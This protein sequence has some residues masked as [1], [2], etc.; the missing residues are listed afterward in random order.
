MAIAIPI[1]LSL[2]YQ[3]SNVDYLSSNNNRL[4][5]WK[6]SIKMFIHNP[7]YGLGAGTDNI[8]TILRD[9]YGLDRSHTHNLF[10]QVIVEGGV[11]GFVFLVLI[12]R[13]IIH[14]LVRL[15]TLKEERYRPYAVVYTASFIAFITISMFEFTL[16]S[17]KEM[18]IFFIVLG[19][20]E[21]TSRMET[22]QLQ[23]AD[24]DLFEYEEISEEDFE[25]AQKR[26]LLK[27]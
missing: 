12:I 20:I 8:H 25:E 16:Q 5:I 10:L 17:A 3:N 15:Y 19:L 14:K 13:T 4:D 24:D 1:A 22:D 21:A 18:M 6:Y 26:S 23:L 2:R 7:I 27:F 9:E 11:I